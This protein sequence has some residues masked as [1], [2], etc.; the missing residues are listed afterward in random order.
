MDF[1]PAVLHRLHCPR[2]IYVLHRPHHPRPTYRALSIHHRRRRAWLGDFTA[3][4]GFPVAV[5]HWS[6]VGGGGGVVGDRRGSLE[7]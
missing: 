2:H 3:V 5:H 6:A 7:G 1:P 4:A